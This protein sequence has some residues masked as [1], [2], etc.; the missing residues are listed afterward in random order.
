MSL[1]CF[2]IK[3]EIYAANLM[4]NKFS[5]LVNVDLEPKEYLKAFKQKTSN[6]NSFFGRERLSLN[7]FENI[8]LPDTHL[9]IALDFVDIS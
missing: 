9:S 2:Y 4:R 5:F 7:L 6:Y 1:L 8:I 3:L